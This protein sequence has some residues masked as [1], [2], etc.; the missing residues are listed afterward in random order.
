MIKM[1]P[2]NFSFFLFFFFLSN[3]FSFRRPSMQAIPCLSMCSEHI[4]D[5]P[6]VSYWE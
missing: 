4:L 1:S 3:E 5:L 2:V 6:S